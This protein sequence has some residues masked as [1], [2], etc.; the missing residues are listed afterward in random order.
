MSTS[1]QAAQAND[2]GAKPA[3]EPNVLRDEAGSC[4]CGVGTTGK[5]R[6]L[7][8]CI[9]GTS[10]KFGNKN[11]NIVELYSRL[12]KTKDQ[13]TFYNSGI[14]TYAEPSWKSPAYWKQVAMNKLDLALALRFEKI[15]LDAY[16]WLSQMYEEGDRIFLFG[17]SRGAYQVRTLAGMIEKV[18]LI[19]KGNEAQIP[20]AFELYARSPNKEPPQSLPD[21][22]NDEYMPWRFKSTF[23]RKDVR[24]H[25][26][27]V[28]DT[29]SSI[30][31]VRPD[32]D[33]PLTTCGMNHVCHF[34]HALALHERRVKFLPEYSYGGAATPEMD[35]N[36][37]PLKNRNTKEVWFSGTH[38]D[39]GG[40][41]A[42]N[43]GLN[44]YGP[45]LRWMIHESIIAGLA[46]EPFQYQT[47]T[48]DSKVVTSPSRSLTSVWWLFEILP[49]KRLSYKDLKDVTRW[50][51]MGASRHVVDGQ[52]IHASVY[53]DKDRV[54]LKACLPNEWGVDEG[55]RPD[56]T[57]LE[58]DL[59]DKVQ[60]NLQPVLNMT[61]VDES[62]LDHLKMLV[63]ISS[64]PQGVNSLQEINNAGAKL[65][66]ALVTVL[67]KWFSEPERTNT[68]LEAI[69][70][71]IS[72]LKK[73]PSG[74]LPK[75]APNEVPPA[76]TELRKSVSPADR[77][78]AE[79]FLRA[80]TVY[81]QLLCIQ[82]LTSGDINSVAFSPDGKHIASGSSDHNIHIWDSKTGKEL[83]VFRGHTELVLSVAYSPDGKRIASGSWD[84]TTRIWNSETGE[85]LQVLRGHTD[86]V[87]SVAFSSP[88]G[89]YIVSGSDDR[90]IRVWDSET[91]GEQKVLRGHSGEVNSVA[92]S[93]DG[94]KIVS[95][96]D[97]QTIRI[98][99][100]E[101]GKR[102]HVLQG[103]TDWVKSVAFSPDGN[104]IV[105]GS[106][107]E[108][109]C[110]WDAGTGEEVGAPLEGHTNWVWSVAYSP[111]GEHSIA[112]GSSDRTVRLWSAET[113]ELLC[114]FEGR[115][116]PVYSVAFSPDGKQI[117]SGSQDGTIRLW[118]V[119]MGGVR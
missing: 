55:K 80:F 20:F 115:T 64:S 41:N 33:L 49:I 25:F 88:D 116:G 29:V 27:G 59:F 78:L 102:L 100:L 62:I 93:P 71:M 40:G 109:V 21:E 31:L 106:R 35:Y 61:E 111:T 97:D 84:G 112:S 8:V 92:C 32:K 4:R 37:K 51:H 3:N 117:A 67:S 47:T 60:E 91:G 79:Q 104:S 54:K 48:A 26:I 75:K 81:G 58:E 1:A 22:E 28:W 15:L 50:P 118:D 16:R 105:S 95:G 99:N 45:A 90:T 113:R 103:D 72:I 107:D 74:A 9:D 76:I 87:R 13:L 5:R 56:K 6:N 23:A 85:Q 43:K 10:N 24:V 66:S 63:E 42:V 14:G 68:N 52:L 108:T 53:T 65:Y 82:S 119:S 57:K 94:K 86:V 39:I 44:S 12:V 101:T 17:F 36:A 83:Q 18:G 2:A 70:S 11:T 98:W 19:H 69:H 46:L 30:G 114:V 77:T 7:V 110:I 73:F 38:S 96:S 89:K 34:R